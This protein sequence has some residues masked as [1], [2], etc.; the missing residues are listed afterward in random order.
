MQVAAHALRAVQ[1]S[2][3]GGPSKYVHRL[4]LRVQLLLHTLVTGLLLPSRTSLGTS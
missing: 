2:W 1:L 4:S 3:L